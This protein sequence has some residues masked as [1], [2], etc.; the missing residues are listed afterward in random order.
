MGKS[1]VASFLGR[2]GEIIVDADAL[3]RKFV[4][5]GEEA[6]DEIR[7]AFGPKVFGPDGELD[8]Q[9]LAR[10]VFS[11]AESR[12]RLEAILHPRIRAAWLKQVAEWR[13][14]GRARGI[15]VIPL[16]YETGA[17]SEFNQVICV[18]ASALTQKRRLLE[19]GWTAGEIAQRN[20]AQWPIERKMDRADG[21]IWNEASIEVCE[22]QCRRIFENK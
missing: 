18:A 11:S 1:T 3:A 14:A 4:Q 5:P 20:G 10:D 22:E 13:A 8:R 19:R 21:V 9:A 15:V 17:E 6:L 2:G 12:G 7:E 16:L